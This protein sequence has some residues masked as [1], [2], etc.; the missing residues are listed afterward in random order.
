[1]KLFVAIFVAALISI[2]YA[3]KNSNKQNNA[4]FRKMVKEAS[5]FVNSFDGTPQQFQEIVKSQ[6]PSGDDISPDKAEKFSNAVCKK[7]RKNSNFSCDDF[8]AAVSQCQ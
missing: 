5:D 3:E 8:K 7:I 6:C 1:M 2:A 4:N